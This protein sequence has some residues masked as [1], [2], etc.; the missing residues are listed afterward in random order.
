MAEDRVSDVISVQEE[1][2]LKMEVA[3]LSKTYVNL[4]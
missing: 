4:C 3:C 1:D 2:T